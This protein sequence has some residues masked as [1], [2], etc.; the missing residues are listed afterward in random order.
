LVASATTPFG[1]PWTPGVGDSTIVRWISADSTRVRVSQTGVV[2]AVAATT[3]SSPT[4]TVN[5]IIQ[6]VVGNVTRA[7]TCRVRVVAEPAVRTLATVTFRPNVGDSVNI[8]QGSTKANVRFWAVGPTNDTLTNVVAYVTS[9]DTTIARPGNNVSWTNAGII[10]ILG[11]RPGIALLTAKT[12]VYGVAKSDTFSIHVGYPITTSSPVMVTARLGVGGVYQWAGSGFSPDVGPG[13]VVTFDNSSRAGGAPGDS[14]DVIFDDSATALAAPGSPTESGNI[15]RLAA[16]TGSV[17]QSAR[18]RQR[19]F[20]TLGAH[21]FHIP[22]YNLTG[23]IN[24]K[25][26]P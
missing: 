19:V 25:A 12:W 3:T 4:T 23:V 1:D 11:Q 13:A 26:T 14:I 6:Q 15:M 10:S 18:Q 9:S 24:V 7:D 5:V 2:T 20:R 16:D 22:Q 17:G 8:A 21:T